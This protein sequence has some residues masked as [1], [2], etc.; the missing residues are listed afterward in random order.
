MQ[1]DWDILRN[2]QRVNVPDAVSKRLLDRIRVDHV[3]TQWYRVAAAVLITLLVSQ[4]YALI[5]Q[6]D[7]QNISGAA[8]HLVEMPDNQLYHD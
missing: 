6:G 1:E 4:G 7:S 5:N 8:H 2:I 3:P